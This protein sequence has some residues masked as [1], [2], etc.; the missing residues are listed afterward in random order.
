MRYDI[1][2]DR[3]LEQLVKKTDLLP[4][5]FMLRC[6][7]PLERMGVNIGDVVDDVPVCKK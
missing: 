6:F 5:M 1:G 7:S 4:C 3:C 2:C